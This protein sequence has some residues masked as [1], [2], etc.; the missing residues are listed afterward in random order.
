MTQA[1]KSTRVA[2]LRRFTRTKDTPHFHKRPP[3]KNELLK[4]PKDEV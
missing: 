3:P 2:S 1:T 4:P